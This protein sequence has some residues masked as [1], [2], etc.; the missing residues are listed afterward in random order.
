MIHVLDPADLARLARLYALEDYLF[1]V[2]TRRFQDT[3]TLNPYDFYAIVSWKSVRPKTKIRS[4]LAKAGKSASDLMRE[5][6]RASTAEEK[7]QALLG[8]WGIGIA[9]AS[10]IL[11]VCY[12]D[13]F[14]VLDYRAWS[15]LR[16][17]S[18]ED[19]PRRYPHTAGDYLQYCLACRELAARVCLSLRSLDRALWAMSWEEDLRA[20]VG[21]G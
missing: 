6:S 11:T 20:L 21:E 5:V 12:P 10:A 18:A 16:Q 14:T 1:E 7:V 2:V 13:E 19:L 4:G 8:V 17:A 15:V 9:M 3:G